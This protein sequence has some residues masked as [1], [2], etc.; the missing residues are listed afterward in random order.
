M[1]RPDP[2]KGAGHESLTEGTAAPQRYAE[3]CTPPRNRYFRD[4]VRYPALRQQVL[5]ARLT[6]SRDPEVALE[7]LAEQL[8]GRAL[9][10][11]WVDQLVSARRVLVIL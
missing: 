7:E 5:G 3:P 9:A 6:L 8:G 10:N 1:T 2:P 11:A 4:S